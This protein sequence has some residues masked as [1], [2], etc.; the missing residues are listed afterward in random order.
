MKGEWTV[1]LEEADNGDLILPLP[2]ELLV[3]DYPWLEGDDIEM[4]VK[5]NGTILMVNVSWIQRN[6]NG[7]G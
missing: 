1:T 2:Q 7:F 6:E 3:G 5:D 4:S